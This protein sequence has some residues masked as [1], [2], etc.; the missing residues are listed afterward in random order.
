MTIIEQSRISFILQLPIKAT[1]LQNVC[2]W[3]LW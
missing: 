2:I 3:D 1:K